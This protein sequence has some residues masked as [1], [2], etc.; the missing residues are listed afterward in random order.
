MKALLKNGR[1]VSP[2]KKIDELLDIYIED[3]I[4]KE[5]GKNIKKDDVELFD[6]TGKTIVPGFI[7]M[8]VHLREPGFEYKE[9]IETGS[10]AARRGGFTSV[11]LYA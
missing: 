2:T 6:L 8:H 10:M 4:I 1:V 9:T 7:D 5:V 3:G 11:L